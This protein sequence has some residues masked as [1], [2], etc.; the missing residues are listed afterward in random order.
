MSD[1]K[2]Q[3][4]AIDQLREG[5]TAGSFSPDEKTPIVCVVAIVDALDAL[6]QDIHDMRMEHEFLKEE[7]RGVAKAINSFGQQYFGA[8]R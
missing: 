4:P 3:K 1:E 7:L 5:L 8:M 6:R 2:T